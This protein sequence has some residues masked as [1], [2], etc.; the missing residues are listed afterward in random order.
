M[1][2]L[3]LRQR[4]VM[5]REQR[6]Q[7]LIA[8]LNTP[9]ARARESRDIAAML[10]MC[11]AQPMPYVSYDPSDPP[12]MGPPPTSDRQKRIAKY[13]TPE[14]RRKE[15][16]EQ[17]RFL[18][19]WYDPGY[20]KRVERFERAQQTRARCNKLLG[21]LSPF[22]IDHHIARQPKRH[23]SDIC[24]LYGQHD[25]ANAT[26]FDGKLRLPLITIAE[27]E[28]SAHGWTSRECN[29][30]RMFFTPKSLRLDQGELYKCVVHEA[31][32]Q[33]VNE[34]WRGRKEYSQHAGHSK[35]F[36][37]CCDRCAEVLGWSVVSAVCPAT[38]WPL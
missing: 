13:N 7:A 24:Q 17:S 2:A 18:F 16:E 23:Q 9:E 19:G 15:R 12:G 1:S 6:R 38:Q 32:H 22:D 36:S 35:F 26:L 21:I 30:T 3:T 34:V 8:S 4:A 29:P 10:A 31:L 25:V 27:G 14:E 11:K 20:R 5:E 37:T 33:L 28:Y